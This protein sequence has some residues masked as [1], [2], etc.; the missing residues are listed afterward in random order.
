MPELIINAEI[1]APEHIGSGQVLVAG[2]GIA[3]VG[4]AVDI[5]G[6]AVTVIDAQGQW[7]LPGFVDALTHPAGG[8][9]EGGFGNRTPELTANDFINA[10]VTSPVGALGTDSI[11]RSLDVLFGKVM[12]LRRQGLGACMYTGAY[13]VPAPTLTGD[14][15]RDICLIDP[16]IGVGEVAVSDHRSAQPTVDE[17]RR[18][19]AEARLGGVISGKAGVV[20]VHL[21]D[22]ERRLAPLREALAGSELPAD[23][24]YPTHVNRN[25]ALLKEAA[26]FACSGAWID[27]TASTTPELIAAGDIAALDAMRMLMEDGAPAERISIS[28]DAGG[29]LPVYENGVLTGLTAAGPDSLLDVF[30]EAAATGTEAATLVLAALTRNPANAL[31]LHDRGRLEAGA[32]ADL[33]LF[34]PASNQLTGVM[35]DGNWLRE[36][37]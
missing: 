21:G 1:F 22:G 4:D 3:A 14:V 16:V 23:A 24:F 29:S 20:F 2:H 18:L 26:D 30:C 15:A 17:L 10:G 13:R 19:A 9:G 5:G 25:S 32:R 11:T 35:S 6:A 28:S 8:G 27:I 31:G 7:L 34:D 36:P 12:E 33:L 37:H